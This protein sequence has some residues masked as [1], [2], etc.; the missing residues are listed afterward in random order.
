ML[1][2]SCGCAVTMQCVGAYNRIQ[3]YNLDTQAFAQ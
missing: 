1:Y 2:Y 3:R